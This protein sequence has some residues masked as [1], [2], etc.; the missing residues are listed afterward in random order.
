MINYAD[1]LCS[2]IAWI[3]NADAQLP[4]PNNNLH[5]LHMCSLVSSFA[6][7]LTLTTPR[8][9]AISVG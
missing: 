2:H 7:W 6:L 9:V 8:E 1:S 3:F 4:F 5:I